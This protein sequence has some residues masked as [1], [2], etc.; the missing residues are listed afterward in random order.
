VPH[1]SPPARETQYEPPARAADLPPGQFVTDELQSD[2]SRFLEE[3]KNV[4]R[5]RSEAG[6][7]LERYG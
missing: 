4:V 5:R 6:L 7:S 1:A 3:I 2:C